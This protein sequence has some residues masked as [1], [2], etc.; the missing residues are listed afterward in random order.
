MPYR[1]LS[2]AYYN[3]AH[4]TEKALGAIQ[5]ACALEP[6]NSRFLLELDQL[7]A[8]AGGTAE[9]RLRVLEENKELLAGRDVLYL[10]YITLLCFTFI[11]FIPEAWV[12]NILFSFDI[13]SIPVFAVA[14][15]HIEVS[16]ASF[17]M[18][19]LIQKGTFFYTLLNQCLIGI[20]QTISPVS[21]ERANI[22]AFKGLISN[23]PSSVVN[24]IIPLVAGIVFASSENPMNNI[25]LYRWAF[26]VCGIGGILFVAFAY[27]G[28]EERTVVH[29]EY[30]AKVKF[31][32]GAKQL[33]T[34]KYGCLGQSA[35][36]QNQ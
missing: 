20:E 8:K 4:N 26:P 10:A 18:F 33:F 5:K 6:Q 15:S 2:I 27:F 32:E 3:K 30:V 25:A 34:N 13:P 1:N 17:I 12:D 16:L 14:A 21:Q 11:P 19:M 23:I 9:E 29:K 28:T 24:I 31:A 22:G 36:N 35:R 7:S